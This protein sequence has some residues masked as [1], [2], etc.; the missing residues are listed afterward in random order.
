[1]E[2]ASSQPRPGP[3]PR[4][5]SR[6]VVMEQPEVLAKLEQLASDSGHS[7]AAEIRSAIRYWLQ[8]WESES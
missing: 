7:V 1:M 6:V 3:P 5:T 8:A 4:F 2:I